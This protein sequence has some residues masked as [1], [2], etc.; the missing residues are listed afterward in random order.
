M[1]LATKAAIAHS[2]AAWPYRWVIA[3]EDSGNSK[4]AT[5][6]DDGD[7]WTIQTTPFG[8]NYIQSVA[9]NG[10]DLWVAVGENGTL[11]TSP[12]AVT[13]TARTSS[14]STSDIYE[15][16]WA[17]NLWVACGQSG[18]VA[19]STDGITWTQRTSGNTSILRGADYGAG[20]YAV[21]GQNSFITSTD[22]ITWTARTTSTQIL[23]HGVH[24]F[25]DQSIWVVG[26][27]TGTT[28]A[29]AS[30]PDAITWTQRTSALNNNGVWSPF[31]SKPTILV[32]NLF[33]GALGITNDTQSST[34]GT[35]YT[36]RGTNGGYDVACSDTGVFLNSYLNST[37]RST[38]GT[39]WTTPSNTGLGNIT[40]RTIAHSSMKP[41]SRP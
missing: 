20:T 6:D 16:I 28:N 37:K 27:D 34:N 35:T 22:G 24:Y 29:M 15:V 12:D 39:S 33:T 10:S 5:S 9:S 41:G 1:I 19:T 26:A 32:N 13:W 21:G 17:N 7:N 2:G 23:Q 14:F 38:N 3:G 30:S 25:A 36:S 4:L 40:G 18:K 8:A 31:A 11:A